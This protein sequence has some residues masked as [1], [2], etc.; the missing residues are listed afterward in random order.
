MSRNLKPQGVRS[1]D[2][3]GVGVWRHP[4]GDRGG[5]KEVW[6]VEQSEDEPGW[7]LSLNCKNK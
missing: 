2:G 3:V 7:R 6:D 4:L 5:G 1:S